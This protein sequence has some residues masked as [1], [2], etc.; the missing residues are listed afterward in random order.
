MRKTSKK[1]SEIFLHARCRCN[2]HDLG[3]ENVAKTSRREQVW[4]ILTV[5]IVFNNILCDIKREDGTALLK[6]LFVCEARQEGNQ[7]KRR[8]TK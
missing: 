6:N 3:M 4:S 2:V 8:H 7:N 5:A 1:Y